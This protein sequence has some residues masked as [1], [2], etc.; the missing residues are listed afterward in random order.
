MEESERNRESM[1][2][3]RVG[4]VGGSSV[5]KHRQTKGKPKAKQRQDKGK[6]KLYSAGVIP[7]GG[8]LY[9]IWFVSFARNIMYSLCA[10]MRRGAENTWRPP[11]LVRA[12]DGRWTREGGE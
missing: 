10:H 6:A 9:E 3:A 1:Y 12:A 7:V 8:H 2:I 4:E 5:I 11:A